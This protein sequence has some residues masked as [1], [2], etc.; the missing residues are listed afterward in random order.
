[1]DR[2]PIHIEN[3]VQFDAVLPQS[4]DCVVIGGGIIGAMAA[5]ELAAQGQ[6]VVVLEKGR[7]AGEQSSRNW[8][9]VRVQGRDPAEIPIMLEAR[10]I[11][12]TLAKQVDC[13]IGLRT[14]GVSFLARTEEKLAEYETWIAH[15]R[16]W[17]LDTCLRSRDAL[18]NEFHDVADIWCG[19]LHTPSD[20]RAEPWVAV[21]AIARKLAKSGATLIENCAVRALEMSAGKISSVVT[22]RGEIKTKRVILAGGAWTSLFLRRHGLSIPQLSVKATVAAT[23]PVHN[24][25]DGNAAD[26]K[27]AFRRRIDGGYT[28]APGDFHELYVGP[29]AFRSFRSYLRQFLDHPQGTKLRFKNLSNYPDAWGTARKWRADE[30]TPFE[31][32]RILNPDPNM[33]V[34]AQLATD[35]GQAFPTL[36]DVKIKC[37]WA[38]MIDATPDVIPIVDNADQI[39]GLTIAT[40]MSGHGFGIGP[41]FGRIAAKLSMGQDTGH[42]LNRFRLSRFFDGSKLEIG[43]GL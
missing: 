4:A 24:I 12:A 19:S 37:A 35:F 22:E 18:K 28:L 20:M 1:M 16:P 33:D 40:G 42:D 36:G 31:R 43:P 9:W 30:E 29:D 10:E 26:N 17:G 14:T 8:G 11:W 34:L 7:I 3:P 27:F 2:F 32:M 41:A 13:D 23:A 15:A 39:P 21:P 38:G 5:W 6:D 25:H